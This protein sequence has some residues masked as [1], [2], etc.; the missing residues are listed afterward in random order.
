MQQQRWT[1]RVDHILAA[2][3]KI[4]RYTAGMT[5]VE[6]A[7]HQL[8]VD[9]VV[10]NFEVIALASGGIPNDVIVRHRDI[11]WSTLRSFPIGAPIR[12]SD[13]RLEAIW[14]EIHNELPALIPR[15]TA[16]RDHEA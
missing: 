11:P 12:P 7:S 16:I 5:F 13:G 15:L 9:A 2:I 8:A 3:D 1:V 6:F 4:Q 10:R 14:N